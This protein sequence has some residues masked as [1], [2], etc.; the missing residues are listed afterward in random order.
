MNSIYKP[1][2]FDI[3]G[4]R[5]ISDET[6]EIHFGLYEGYVRETN[7][8]NEVIAEMVNGGAAEAEK[9]ATFSELKRRLAFE[10]N[11]MILHEYYFDNLRKGGGGEPARTSAFRNIAEES[12]GSFQAW[13]E[14][15]TNVGRMR[16]VGWAIAYLNASTGGLSNQWVTLHENGHLAGLKPVLVM[17]AWEHAFLLDYTPAERPKY[18]EAFFGN[19]DWTAVESRM[20]PRAVPSG[21]AAQGIR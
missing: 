1:R 15:F 14:D 9:F 19:V 5:G 6:L 21:A 17:D 11:G 18:I 13:R 12:F 2:H 7:R 20:W 10:F 3:D 8:L 4:L 16:G